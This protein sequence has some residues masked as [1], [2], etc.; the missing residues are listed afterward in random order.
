MTQLDVLEYIHQCSYV[1]G[2]LKGANMLL[3]RGKGGAAQAYLVDFG[4]ACHYTTAATFKPDPKKMHNGTIEY[5]SRDAHHG[6]PTMRGDL[7]ILAYNLINW[8]GHKLPWELDAKILAAPPKVQALKE[9]FMSDT[10]ASLDRSFGASVCPTAVSKYF[11]YIAGMQFSDTP[12]YGKCRKMFESALSTM[13]VS[14]QGDLEFT[15]MSA[16]VAAKKTPVKKLTPTKAAAT[17]TAARKRSFATADK[18]SSSIEISDSDD[19]Y[20]DDDDKPA[21]A[22]TTKPTPKKAKK[23]PSPMKMKSP[24]PVTPSTTPVPPKKTRKDKIYEVNMLDISYDADVVI[25]IRRRGDSKA[26]KYVFQNADVAG[27]VTPGKMTTAPPATPKDSN[28]AAAAPTPDK[29]K[30]KR[31][32]FVDLE[33]SVTGN[34]INIKAKKRTATATTTPKKAS[35]STST[36]KSPRT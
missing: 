20:E 1:H 16:A 28:A 10:A 2:D 6:V 12:D 27:K 33:Q 26:R 24:P 15:K 25:N 23:I 14:N 7:E 11:S 18:N 3:G 30:K 29:K 34:V 4:L 22:T 31:E 19:N 17:T 35:S 36:R 32:I 9:S 5:T 8:F 13:K 21:A